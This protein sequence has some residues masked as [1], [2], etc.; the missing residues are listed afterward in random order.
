I[1]S[2][3]WMPRNLYDRVEVMVPLRDESIR[4]RVR[5][6]ILEAYLRDNCK[7]RI[8][9]PDGSY[10]RSSPTGKK[11]PAGPPSFSAQ[12]FLMDLAEGKQTLDALRKIPALPAPITTKKATA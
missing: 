7:A 4:R 8:M 2:A 11:R 12:E 10:V 1:G 6:E 9:T 5:D 3:D